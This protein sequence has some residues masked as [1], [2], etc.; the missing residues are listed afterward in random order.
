MIHLHGMFIADKLIAVFESAPAAQVF[1]EETIP[2]AE[3]GAVTITALEVTKP[4]DPTPW[5]HHVRDERAAQPDEAP[6]K[7]GWRFDPQHG[8]S[9]NTALYAARGGIDP[10]PWLT[11]VPEGMVLRGRDRWATFKEGYRT[12]NVFAPRKGFSTDPAAYGLSLDPMPWVHGHRRADF[13]V[14]TLLEP[15]PEY[16]QDRE[17]YFAV[18]EGKAHL[19]K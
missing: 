6:S 17:I 12:R 2:V 8:F 3:H 11:P 13:V 10:F 19:G 9:K 14:G 1:M 16:N 18:E 15:R 7:R 5:Y 4:L